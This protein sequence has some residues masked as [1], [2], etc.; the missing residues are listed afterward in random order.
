MLAQAVITYAM[1]THWCIWLSSSLRT[2]SSIFWL[3][4]YFYTCCVFIPLILFLLGLMPDWFQFFLVLM[5]VYGTMFWFLYFK[6]LSA[7]NILSECGARV[8]YVFPPGHFWG[9]SLKERGKKFERTANPACPLSNFCLP[10]LHTASLFRNKSLN[11]RECF[12]IW[13]Q[14]PL[15]AVSHL[16]LWR[17]ES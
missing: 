10:F 16:T 14:A 17:C 4:A 1:Y 8:P 15:E 5:F 9:C 12:V 7:G 3:F 6:F 13:W 11:S 2:Y